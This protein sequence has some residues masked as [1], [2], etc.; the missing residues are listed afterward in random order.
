MAYNIETQQ[1]YRNAAAAQPPVTGPFAKA[2]HGG[3][4]EDDVAAVHEAAQA[5]EKQALA[6]GVQAATTGIKDANGGAQKRSVEAGQGATSGAHAREDEERRKA[7]HA[8][9]AYLLLM[10]RLDQLNEEI[11][12]LNEEI[13]RMREEIEIFEQDF[14]VRYGQS[15]A[16]YYAAKYLGEDFEHRRSGEAREAYSFR[17]AREI[18][19][20]IDK[21]EIVIDAAE[22]PLF[23]QGLKYYRDLERKQAQVRKIEDGLDELKKEGPIN[24]HDPRVIE[25][26]RKVDN[27][28]DFQDIE[29][30]RVADQVIIER[31]ER[32]NINEE[33]V[34]SASKRVKSEFDHASKPS[35]GTNQNAR[36]EYENF[37][38]EENKSLALK[39]HP[40][41]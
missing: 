25:L 31:R 18:Q 19:K 9:N 15:Y 17:V 6:Y 37:T 23:E 1:H 27:W 21:G 3:P 11:A 5:E 26:L 22:D 41:A 39:I 34:F 29:S 20:K 40:Q 7:R 38:A 2:S 28:E 36:K 32:Q 14:I 33:N 10:L 12:R 8:D 16:E 4:P 30:K 24:P 35:A 13:A